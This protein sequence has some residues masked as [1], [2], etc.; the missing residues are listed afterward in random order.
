MIH[1]T[2]LPLAI[3]SSRFELQH[4]IGTE[5][6]G[7]V[8]ASQYIVQVNC[9]SHF[10]I[11]GRWTAFEPEKGRFVPEP[12]VIQALAAMGAS[13]RYVTFKTCPLFYR[14]WPEFQGSPPKPESYPQAGEAVSWLLT[15]TGAK[16]C[17]YRN[18]DNTFSGTQV[19]NETQW[20]Y[21]A[22]IGPGETAY[23]GGKRHGEAA[24]AIREIVRKNN[25][26][27]DLIIGGIVQSNLNPGGHGSEWIRGVMDGCGGRLP[28]AAFSTHY[29]I[30]YDWY[31]N[32]T[33][34]GLKHALN[35]METYLR[36][37]KSIVRLPIFVSE[38]HVTTDDD[39]PD[40]ED[41][42]K[43]WQPAYI[44]KLA[45]LRRRGIIV[46]NTVYQWAGQYSWNYTAMLR[47]LTRPDPD[48]RP[49]PAFEAWKG[50]CV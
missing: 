42:R 46:G 10:K 4:P 7:S 3:K 50:V 47:G 35:T 21:G 13:E 17:E 25:P 43:I 26:G 8:A 15:L 27:C 20:Y 49:T 38:G 12:N 34:E 1:K 36:K 19:D 33:L 23:I 29:Y 28:G 16:Y 39:N 24:T 32:H 6:E 14:L 44:I 2:Y 18:E 11:S 40:T 30:D 22:G 41:F 9:K 5:F 31:P 37:L 48:L 45:E